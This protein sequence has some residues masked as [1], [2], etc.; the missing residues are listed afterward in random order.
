M[1]TRSVGNQVALAIF[2]VIRPFE[3]RYAPLYASVA[4]ATVI[5]LLLQ[6]LCGPPVYVGVLLVVLMSLLIIGLNWQRLEV[7]DMFP[8]LQR[9]QLI[10]RLLGSTS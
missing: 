3:F 9:I 1:V 8:E 6:W 5:L 10:Q 2:S 7:D 4:V